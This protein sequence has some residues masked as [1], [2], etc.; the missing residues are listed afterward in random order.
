MTVRNILEDKDTFLRY[1]DR[2]MFSFVMLFN[3]PRTYGADLQM[4]SATRELI[5][6]ALACSGRYY[7]P[8]RLHATAAQFNLA[9][10][11]AVEFFERKRF[12]DPDEI[13]QNK[14]Y[15]KY[16]KS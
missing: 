4:E 5:D 14:F 15:L 13:F 12:Y 1:A 7:L 16:G 11:K 8:Y 3:Q 9:Y 6:A 10:P 2:E